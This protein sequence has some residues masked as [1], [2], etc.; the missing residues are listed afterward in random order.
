M[1]YD[2][3][4]AMLAKEK[5]PQRHR[6]LEGD[7]QEACVKYFR[8]AYPNYIIFSVPNGGTRNSREAVQLK[9]EGALAGVAD[10]VVVIEGAVLFV[11][12]KTKNNK[13]QES[14]KVFQKNVER[15]GHQ[16]SVCH[17]LQEFQLAIERFIKDRFGI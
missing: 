15:L 9:R 16:Y 13:Q 6:H 8:Y 11:E 17:S 1:K 2:E 10:L 12:M 4:K 5:K 14:Q 7:I 3:L